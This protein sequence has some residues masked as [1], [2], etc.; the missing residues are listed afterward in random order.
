MKFEDLRNL[1][2]KARLVLF[3]NERESLSAL[4]VPVRDPLAQTEVGFFDS[5]YPGKTFDYVI[6]KRDL[7]KA[8]VEGDRLKVRVLVSRK[9]SKTGG[10]PA[11]HSGR[12]YHAFMCEVRFLKLADISL[13]E[14]RK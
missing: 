2:L 8:V 3:L 14:F 12:V 9:A 1:C 4:T 13:A 11:R 6:L 7:A 10:K 5:S